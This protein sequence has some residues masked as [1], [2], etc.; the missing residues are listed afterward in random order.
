MIHHLFY[1]ISQIEHD[2]FQTDVQTYMVEYGDKLQHSKYE[3]RYKRFLLEKIKIPIFIDL[4]NKLLLIG[5]SVVIFLMYTK[6][7]ED[8]ALQLNIQYNTINNL[9]INKEYLESF[10]NNISKIIILTK[11]DMEGVSLCDETGLYP[12]ASLISPCIGI[13]NIV[14]AAGRTS[15]YKSG[16]A[17]TFYTINFKTDEEIKFI[18]DFKKSEKNE[19]WL[20]E[21]I[22]KY[23][24]TNV[25]NVTNVN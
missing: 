16:S 14:Q 2:K 5:K 22:K 21:E 6:N 7:A 13:T 8:I 3:A 25:T 4:A 12:R 18:K 17:S 9:N 23:A 24:K 15:G 11:N 19:Y 1:E 10:T 20:E